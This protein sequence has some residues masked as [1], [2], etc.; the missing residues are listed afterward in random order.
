MHIFVS[1]PCQSRK[2]ALSRV[3]WI[4]AL[5]MIYVRCTVRA[6][7]FFCSNCNT[8]KHGNTKVWR[9]KHEHIRRNWRKP[10][11]EKAKTRKYYDKNTKVRWRRCENKM[12]CQSI[13]IEFSSSCFRLFLIVLS[14][15]R[16]FEFSRFRVF[17]FSSSYFRVFEFLSFWGS[18]FSLFHT[19]V[20][21]S[22]RG[23]VF[24]PFRLRTFVLSPS[25]R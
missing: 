5:R 2:I 20:F 1:I 18:V 13:I 17:G 25:G 3:A 7:A 22:F 23:F 12:T 9:L 11:E 19:F 24:S 6:I 4:N 14:C 16:V 21:S 15:F 8:R 10:E